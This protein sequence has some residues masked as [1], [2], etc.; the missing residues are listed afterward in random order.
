MPIL[1]T[2]AL[3]SSIAGLAPGKTVVLPAGTHD[4][5]NISRVTF[6]PPA[7]IDLGGSTVRGFNLRGVNGLIIR[8]GRVVARNGKYPERD[9]LGGYAIM[10]RSNKNLILRDLEITDAA[11]GLIIGLSTG[12]K[13]HN[14]TF[15]NIRADGINV[16]RS[17]QILIDGV[18]CYDFTPR[19]H[20][21]DSNGKKIKEGDH[22][23]CVQGW[24]RPSAA[25]Q[26]DVV[27]RNVKARGRMQGIFFGN[28]VRNGVNDGG[29]DRIVV[30]NN[31]IEN[32]YGQHG[33]TIGGARD[34]VVRNNRVATMKGISAK[35]ASNINIGGRDREDV[36][37]CGNIVE[38]R[39]AGSKKAKNAME[40]C[41]ADE[42]ARFPARQP[43]FA[44]ER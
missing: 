15:H 14:V 36:T 13:V 38:G 11:K 44:D 31:D 7:T 28:H 9:H 33:I 39:A 34:T 8:N 1:T 42:L 16:A 21:Y 23:D 17:R 27:I 3:A 19:P 18:S 40:S 32:A 6:D 10:A 5:I 25:P 41:T 29:Y 43:K 30:E 4:P 2:L 35:A 22:P 24:S 12:I 26:S 20:E 37:I